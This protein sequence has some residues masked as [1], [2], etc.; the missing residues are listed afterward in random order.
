[1]LPMR[2]SHIAVVACASLALPMTLRVHKVHKQQLDEGQPAGLSVHLKH[3]RP[4]PLCITPPQLTTCPAVYRLL[5]LH[6][7]CCCCCCH[8]VP[9]KVVRLPSSSSS[10]SRQCCRCTQPP[11]PPWVLWRQLPRLLRPQLTQLQLPTPTQP[12]TC[13]GGC[14]SSSP[15]GQSDRIAIGDV[16]LTGRGCGGVFRSFWRPVAAELVMLC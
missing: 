4:A 16:I 8:Q 5:L 1:M 13:C 15:R 9:P 10:S 12:A 7:C 14:R 11:C 2:A 6:C 3:S